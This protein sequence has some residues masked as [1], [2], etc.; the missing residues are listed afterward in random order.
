MNRCASNLL[1]RNL[2]SSILRVSPPS[3]ASCEYMYQSARCSL[4][5]Y[6]RVFHR[7][8]SHCLFLFPCKLSSAAYARLT[9]G[10]ILSL[11]LFCCIGTTDSE[12]GWERTGK[13]KD[14]GLV[15]RAPISC[16]KTRSTCV[17]LLVMQ[18]LGIFPHNL[19]LTEFPPEVS[20]LHSLFT[21]E[22]NRGT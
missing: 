3:S 4:P 17:F 13:R 22:N 16:D 10:L 18:W 14:L 21:L 9:P 6:Q 12:K 11:F 5:A 2:K 19:R 8:K 15:T 1:C 7:R 20:T